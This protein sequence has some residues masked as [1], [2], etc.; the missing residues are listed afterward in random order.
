MGQAGV[1][2]RRQGM[3]E[4]RYMAVENTAFKCYITPVVT[5]ATVGRMFT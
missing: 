4:L 5:L 2:S 3:A 1:G